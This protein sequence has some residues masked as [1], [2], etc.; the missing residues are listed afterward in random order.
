VSLTAIKN[1]QMGLF[2]LGA[3]QAL[4]AA[5]TPLCSWLLPHQSIHPSIGQV[6][7]HAVLS[8][9]LSTAVVAVWLVFRSSSWAWALQDLLGVSLIVMVLRQFR[10]PDIKVRQWLQ[11]LSSTELC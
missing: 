7:V 10:L 2:S 9:S 6:P 4:A 3:I 1:V 8:L 5:L 11:P